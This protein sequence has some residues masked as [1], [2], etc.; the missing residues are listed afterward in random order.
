MNGN[1]EAPAAREAE[2]VVVGGPVLQPNVADHHTP[3]GKESQSDESLLERIV[4]LRVKRHTIG[5][6]LS[7]V[8]VREASPAAVAHIQE[9][10]T[11]T[12]VGLLRVSTVSGMLTALEQS[13]NVHFQSDDGSF[14]ALLSGGVSARVKELH[15]R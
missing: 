13:N 2:G 10:D 8:G 12:G 4:G 3:D 11:V 6:G 7:V 9:G 1:F 15:R 5:G 14:T